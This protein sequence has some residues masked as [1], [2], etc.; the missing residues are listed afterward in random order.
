MLMK[1]DLHIHH[2]KFKS[3]HLLKRIS[4]YK[5]K[6]HKMIYYVSNSL[7]SFPLLRHEKRQCIQKFENKDVPRNDLTD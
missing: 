5:T 7:L 2:K 4:Q 3:N 6:H 1:N